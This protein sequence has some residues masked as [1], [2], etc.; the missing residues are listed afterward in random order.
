[1]LGGPLG[2]KEQHT[3]GKMKCRQLSV[4]LVWS[5]RRLME[6]KLER[7]TDLDEGA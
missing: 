3:C 1:M 4:A 5:K 6:T 7:W 2:P